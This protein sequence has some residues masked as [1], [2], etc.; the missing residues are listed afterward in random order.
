MTAK[1]YGVSF[2]G[3]DNVLQLNS[4]YGCTTLWIYQNPLKCILYT[5]AIF[6]VWIISSFK[7]TNPKPEQESY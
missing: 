7:N 1:E 4:S 2:W 5:G 6:A 3:Y